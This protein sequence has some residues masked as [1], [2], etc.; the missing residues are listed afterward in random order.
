MDISSFSKRCNN[1]N[2]YQEKHHIVTP[3]IQPRRRPTSYVLGHLHQKPFHYEPVNKS[4]IRWHTIG[5]KHQLKMRTKQNITSS[6]L[7]K[8]AYSIQ[9]AAFLGV[10]ARVHKGNFTWGG[11]SQIVHSKHGVTPG[12]ITLAWPL[13]PSV[14]PSTI[15][16]IVSSCGLSSELYSI[17]PRKRWFTILE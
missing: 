11:N 12:K 17:F 9:W 6:H 15:G 3:Y 7:I 10:S 8:W 14:P 13:K 16:F 1:E 2:Q 5:L 4:M